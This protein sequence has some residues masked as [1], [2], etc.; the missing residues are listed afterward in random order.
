M[1]IEQI[2]YC[3][4]ALLLGMLLANM[5]QNVCGCNVVE[6]G[7]LAP[8][9]PPTVYA[10]K[11]SIATLGKLT[12]GDVDLSADASGNRSHTNQGPQPQSDVSAMDASI[13]TV[14]DVSVNA[15][16]LSSVS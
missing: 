12:G 4:F 5:L 7:G 9:T 8:A 16:N 15:L 11:G 3:V 1:K 2:M 10:G 6:G 14:G 13:A